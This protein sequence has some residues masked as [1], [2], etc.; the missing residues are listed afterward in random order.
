MIQFGPP[1]G[2]PWSP[3]PIFTL[4]TTYGLGSPDFFGQRVSSVLNQA[5]IDGNSLMAESKTVIKCDGSRETHTCKP[6]GPGSYLP[7]PNSP[8]VLTLNADG[9]Y[10]ERCGDGYVY[11]YGT[12]GLINRI[13]N[14]SGKIWTLILGSPVRYIVDPASRRTT[15]SYDSMTGKLRRFQDPFGRLTTFTLD[16]GN[17]L[18]QFI[19][20][21][22]CTTEFRYH[23]VDDRL[24]AIISPE[25]LRTSFAYTA[26][27]LCSEIREPSG[28]V[29]AYEYQSWQRTKVTAP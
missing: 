13:T 16:S 2:D 19:T 6:P 3:I 11:D 18:T 12:D 23:S 28:G 4:N 27:G 15:L 10:T 22:L 9:T 8:N 25:G 26:D 21:E 5:V 29:Y 17:R 24:K 1:E 14:P 7:P 20:P